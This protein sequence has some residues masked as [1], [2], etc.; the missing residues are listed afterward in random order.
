MISGCA[1]LS[2]TETVESTVV[3]IKRP[4]L[5][6]PEPDKLNMREVNWIVVNKQNA[7]EVFDRIS[8]NGE[9]V[10]IIGLT[11]TDYA[12]MA[13]NVND[14]RSFIEQQQIIIDAYNDYYIETDRLLDELDVD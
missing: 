14:L 3:E 9:L 1:F 6:L 2:R 10:S 12:R 4:E 7:D 11:P 8:T 5:V 13:S